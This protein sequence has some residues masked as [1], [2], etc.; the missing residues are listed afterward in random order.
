MTIFA[1]YSIVPLLIAISAPL[2]W[3]DSAAEYKML[4][5]QGDSDASSE[6]NREE[7]SLASEAW[8][9]MWLNVRGMIL[10]SDY[11]WLLAIFSSG[12]VRLNFF[13]GSLKLQLLHGAYSSKL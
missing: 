4:A 12:L 10:S 3:A 5:P 13:L 8:R 1:V 6:E 7:S 9:E 2:L 11:A